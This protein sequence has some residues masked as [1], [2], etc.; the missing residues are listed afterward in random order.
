MDMQISFDFPAVT[1][2]V[3]QCT[4]WSRLFV[5]FKDWWYMNTEKQWDD[6]GKQNPISTATFSSTNCAHSH[7]QLEMRP[8]SKRAL[9]KY[10]RFTMAINWQCCKIAGQPNLNK[11]IFKSSTLRVAAYL[12]LDAV[13]KYS[14]FHW[15]ANQLHMEQEIHKHWLQH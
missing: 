13:C 8:T 12:V 7:L 1:N 3:P 11:Q 6:D 10:L 14:H 15:L 9:C 5:H 2:H 4:A